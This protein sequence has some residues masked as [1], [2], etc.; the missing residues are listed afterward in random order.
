M[1]SNKEEFPTRTS[2]QVDIDKTSPQDDTTGRTPSTY[3]VE[4]ADSL[5][6]VVG[7]EIL[8]DKL[9]NDQARLAGCL[10]SAS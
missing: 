5:R 10:H 3:V 2:I 6:S 9:L 8:H 4:H 7:L 1:K